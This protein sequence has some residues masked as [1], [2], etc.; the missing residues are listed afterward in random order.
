MKTYQSKGTI[1]VP[2]PCN[3]IYAV[4]DLFYYYRSDE[5]FTYIFLPRYSVIDLLTAD[6]FQGIQGLDLSLRK[7]E[8]IRENRTPTFISERVPQE[9]RE[10]YYELLERVG[11]N[12]MEPI[13]YLIKVKQMI[14]E[15]YFGDTLFMKPYVEK[16]L[17]DY[18]EFESHLTNSALLK[19][20]LSNICLGHDIKIGDQTINDTNRKVFHDIFLSF[21][22]RSYQSQKERQKAGIETAKKD[23]KYQGRKAVPISFSDFQAAV[24]NVEMGLITAKEAAK[25][26]GISID[27]YYRLKKRL[28]K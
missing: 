24:S 9:S 20:M 3:L 5:T 8:Y 10:D 25:R 6:Y 23:G 2:G 21:Y 27:K 15:Q 19:E 18:D 26:L 4:C 7:N 11:M 13:E 28:F 17:I 16:Q 22:L 1:C 14:N 12:H